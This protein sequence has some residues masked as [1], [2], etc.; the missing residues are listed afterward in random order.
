MP[1]CCD[2]VHVSA[3]KN[4]NF[5]FFL[6]RYRSLVV[7]KHFSYR[8]FQSNRPETLSHSVSFEQPRCFIW[9]RQKAESV[10]FVP[11]GNLFFCVRKMSGSGRFINP[12]SLPAGI[13]G[14]ATRRDAAGN[15]LTHP[16]YLRPPFGNFCKERIRK[17]G[18]DPRVNCIARFFVVCHSYL[19]ETK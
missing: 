9:K 3:G 15:S 8:A 6:F 19:G 2:V 5:L 4:I 16:Y 17:D 14:P 1:Y 11:R 13:S 7:V 18:S 12:T 10:P